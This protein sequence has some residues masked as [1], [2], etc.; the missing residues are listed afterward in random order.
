MI[1]HR[2]L[3]LFL[4]AACNTGPAVHPV[5]ETFLLKNVIPD[6]GGRFITYFLDP[7][8]CGSCTDS[9][10][11]FINHNSPKDYSVIV[12]LTF[13][14]QHVISSLKIRHELKIINQEILGRSGLLTASAQ[15]FALRN[16]K[17]IYYNLLSEGN[18]PLIHRDLKNL[19]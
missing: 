4:L 19:Q 12:V 13:P 17:I 14:D 1:T 11:Q 9:T 15:V 8:F 3:A 10:L 7:S 6:S 5:T 16:R 2:L 18:L